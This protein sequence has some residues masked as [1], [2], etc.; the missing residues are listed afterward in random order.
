MKKI[1]RIG[2]KEEDYVKEVLN[3]QFRSSKGAM[4]MT[5]F[6][7]EFAKK[8]NVKFAISHINGTATLHSCLAAAGIGPGDEVIVPPLTMSSTSFAVIQQNAVAIFADIDP[9]TFVIDAKY[10]K[11]L[12]TERTKAIITVALYGLSPDM[13]PI[14]DLAKKNNLVVIEDNAQAFLSYYKGKLAGTIGHMSSFSLQS[15][16][17]ITAGEGGI[18]LT[19]DEKLALAVRR[20]SSLGYAGVGA[21]KGKITKKDIQNPNYERHVQMGYNYRMPELC[22]AVALAQT[23]RMDELVK[24]RAEVAKLFDSVIKEKKCSWLVPQKI[25]DYAKSSFWTFVVKLENPKVKWEDFQKKFL[26]LGGDGFYAAWKLIYQEPMFKTFSFNF[27]EKVY[28]KLYKGKLQDY[29]SSLCPNAEV[30]QKKLIQFKTNFWDW[31]DAERNA[32]VLRK[33]IDFFDKKK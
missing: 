17:H 12:I 9:D 32:E 25:P 7:Q 16:K 4:M 21:G 6:E 27:V 31:K 10:I 20:F 30:L 29:S 13:D 24:R 23:E 26:E 5:R 18:V 14:M 8:Y 15:S 28:D 3:T 2:K 1:R 22:A 19:N 11:P 33:T